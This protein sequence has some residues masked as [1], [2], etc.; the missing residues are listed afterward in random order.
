MRHHQALESDPGS[1]ILF[2]GP[3]LDSNSSPSVISELGLSSS[4]NEQNWLNGVISDLST[5][6]AGASER[7]P[8]SELVPVERHLANLRR[9]L[10][11]LPSSEVPEVLPNAVLAPLTVLAQSRK[12]QIYLQDHT[13]HG[14]DAHLA[15]KYT[16]PLGFC[17]GLLTR[18]A[19][20]S[21]KSLEDL[22]H[23]I[24]VAIRLA[25]LIGA[26]V[27]AEEQHNQHGPA[28][29]F[30]AKWRH[31]EGELDL[32]RVTGRYSDYAYVSVR[33]DKCQ[34]TVTASEHVTS[35]LTQEL[36][37]VG[38]ITAPI[39]LRGRFH[40]SKHQEAFKALISL[41][42]D[43]PGLRFRAVPPADL[44]RHHFDEAVDLHEYALRSILLDECNWYGTLSS[45]L[46]EQAGSL[47][48][49]T[50]TTLDSS[51]CVP[52]SLATRLKSRPIQKSM[53][54]LGSSDV[55]QHDRDSSSTQRDT[56]NGHGAIANNSHTPP[57]PNLCDIAIVGM[58]IK[59]A[60]A[61]DLGEFA[62]LIRTGQSQHREVSADR[63]PLD[64]S[65]WRKKNQDNK[66]WYGNFM[67]DVDSFDHKFF[68]KTPREC[69]AMDPQQRLTLQAAYQAVEQSGYFNNQMPTTHNN[70]IGVYIGACA[71]DYAD[72]A[73]CHE[74]R[75]FTVMGLLRAPIAG[76]VSH[77]F[78]WTGPSMTLDTACSGAAVSIHLAV[79]AL[80]S[81]ECSAALCGGVNVI[82]NEVWFQNLAGASF[83]SPTGQCKPFDEA[84]DGYC[85]GEGVG[86]V[87]LK[88][89]AAA[90]ADGNQIFGRI[91]GT[92]VYQNHNATPLFVP[93][94]PSLSQLFRDVLQQADL[95][96]ADVSVVE[97]HG[98]GTPVGDPA[99]YEAVLQSLGGSN[100]PAKLALGSVK[101]L[102]GHT[103]SASGVVSLVKVLMMMHGSFIPPQASHYKISHRIRTSATDMIDI[104]TTIQ[105]WP[106]HQKAA[107]V[108]NYG[109]SGSNA[110]LIVT[111]AGFSTRSS[112]QLPLGTALPF[113]ISG[114]DG[115]AIV[116]FCAKL[117]AFINKAKGSISLEDI[118]FSLNRQSN[119]TLP[120]GL[121]FTC[122]SVP[123]LMEQLS[124]SSA[125]TTVAVKPP[126][127]V[128]LCFGGQ[129]SRALSLDRAVFDSTPLMRHHLN[130][131][132]EI[133]QT[134]GVESIFPDIFNG[135]LIDDPVH[136]QTMLFSLQ[137][138][139][140]QCWIDSGVQ[141]EAVVGHSFGEIS[142]LCI[143][144]AL[145]LRDALRMVTQ[146]ATIIRNVWS[147]DS[148]AMMMADG[149]EDL[150]RDLVAEVNR[151]VSISRQQCC[152]ACY[153]GPRNFTLAG[154]TEAITHVA[155]VLSTNPTY[156][157]IRSKRL[158][159]TNAFHS[160][161]VQPLLPSLR[162][163]GQEFEFRTPK[164]RLERATETSSN[165]LPISPNFP[166]DHM[167]EPVFFHHAVRR[168]VKDYPSAIWL[169]AGSGS[170][171]T[172]VVRRTAETD[173]GAYF[174]PVNVNRN[175]GLDS[176]ADITLSLWKQGL[177]AIFW[178]HH[179]PYAAS[180]RKTL[181]LP[182]YQ[183]EKTQH[184][185]E[186]VPPVPIKAEDQDSKR[187]NDLSGGLWTFTGFQDRE[188]R[189]ALFKV[190]TKSNTFVEFVK[191]HSLVQTAPICPATLQYS[192]VIEA[193][194]S[195]ME[196]FP[197]L[198]GQDLYPSINDM[199]NRVPLCLNDQS[200]WLD[201][202]VAE[203]VTDYRSWTWKII[204][205]DEG[206]QP[207]PG[208]L[209]HS[210][211][212]VEG[213]L[214]LQTTDGI[215]DFA[216]YE[217]LVTHEQ[218]LS[219]LKDESEAQDILQ[220]HSVYRS[221][222]PAVDYGEIYR[223][224]VR[225]V[226]R[227]SEC[228]G[229]VRYPSITHTNA[230]VVGWIDDIG[231]LDAFCQVAGVYVNCMQ[232]AS[233]DDVFLATGVEAIIRSPHLPARGKR[234][235]PGS[236][237]HI[238]ARHHAVSDKSF[239]TDLFVF[240]AKSGQLSEIFLG[241]NYSRAPRASLSRL[242]ARLSKA[243]NRASSNEN[244]RAPGTKPGCYGESPGLA[245]QIWDR[246]QDET[247]NE[248]T[249]DQPPH[250][251]EQRVST[252][253]QNT[254]IAQ[255]T[256]AVVANML[257]IQPDE[258]SDDSALADMGIDSLV[259]MELTQEIE[260]AFNC[261]LPTTE[262]LLE[263]H[264]LRELIVL[265]G[266]LVHGSSDKNPSDVF[267][268]SDMLSDSSSIARDTPLYSG[269]QVTSEFTP[270]ENT[271]VSSV[272]HQEDDLKNSFSVGDE[273]LPFQVPQSE[274]IR[275]FDNVKKSTDERLR[276]FG[277]DQTDQITVAR[278][279]RLCVALVVEAFELL[280]CSLRSAKAGQPLMRI[281]H[282]PQHQRL[283]D[284]LYRF[285]E[286]DARL[287]DTSEGQLI[288]TR[289]TIGAQT[290]EFILQNLIDAQD[291]WAH[292]HR[293]VYH[294]GKS[295]AD[296]LMGKTDGIAVIFGSVRGR[297]LV[298]ALYCDLPFNRLFYEQMRDTIGSLARS[299]PLNSVE[300]LRILEMGAGTCS[301]TIV[302]APYLASL[303][304][305]VVYTVTDLSPS[306]VAQAR[307]NF[308]SQYPFMKFATHDIEQEP[309]ENLRNQHIVV[310]SNA[311]HATHDLPNSLSK[312]RSA[313][314]SNG[315]LLL[316]EMTEG[317][318][319]VDLVFGLLEGW[320]R[321][322]DGRTNAIVS[323]THWD[324][325]LRNA[326]FQYVDWTDGRLPENHIQK[327]IMAI[328]SNPNVEVSQV[329]R[330]EYQAE[331]VVRLEPPRRA[332]DCHNYV[333]KYV[334]GFMASSDKQRGP[335]EKT[336]QGADGIG[337]VITGATGS[338]GSHLVAC[339]AE[340]PQISQVVI[341]DRSPQ[342]SVSASQRMRD[343]FESRK[344]PVKSEI[345]A[346]LRFVAVD[347]TKPELGLSQKD[348]QSLVVSCTHIIHNGWPMSA[349]RVLASFEP[350]FKSIRHLIDLAAD[351]STYQKG[352]AVPERVV[353]QF[354][355]SI[356]TVGLHSSPQHPR[357]PE[358]TVSIQYALTVGYCEAKW[359]C[360]RLVEET[361]QQHPD[362]FRAMILRPGQIAGST[363]N[364]AWNSHE[365]FAFMLKSAQSLR[366]FPSLEG[367]LQWIPVDT[368]AG[369]MSDLAL[370]AQANC[371]VYH[372][373]N[374][375]GQPWKEMV[376]VLAES[377]NIPSSNIIPFTDWV[378]RVRRSP[379][380]EMD[381]P[382]LR[383]VDFLDNFFLHMSCGG[384]ILD[385]TK[386]QEHSPTLA[387]RGPI[388]A[389]LANKYVRWWKCEGILNNV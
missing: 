329:P 228:A 246:R 220:G 276:A 339:L 269:S 277:V 62:D 2:F 250:D 258:I 205:L 162:E 150:I 28:S 291:P 290:S 376:P 217:R 29:A 17:I 46:H 358:E 86:F 323:A 248:I 170:S 383:V 144:G 325:C 364:G 227:P 241:I 268:S 352:S 232:S 69:A 9:V 73:A 129:A 75:A 243:D 189:H 387:A 126:R 266:K 370:N 213:R 145:E 121:F 331:E 96:P 52:P 114:L 207:F 368:V 117:T 134:L 286:H 312:I 136:L 348:Y 51:R 212:C 19:V 48:S 265:I 171:I 64:T 388:P 26:V 361:L 45:V 306:M 106:E 320:W 317:F 57:C 84:A 178:P 179:G 142:A 204:A 298:K 77:F 267:V 14:S 234:F 65:Q 260:R 94:A 261:K 21:A 259:S 80:L 24:T 147:A 292:A 71:V 11:Q 119:R 229:T 138:T 7:I 133:L 357:I 166:A 146:R 223:G 237:W 196:E 209:K 3:Q 175:G 34:A 128:I 116:E 76:R 185:L 200:V 47:G 198:K 152:I 163:M 89:M 95:K 173:Q 50:H 164:I 199:S 230:G 22:S 254:N 284:W 193:L 35:R 342:S 273:A 38:I 233:A 130:M 321:F 282:E 25:L 216:R 305:P 366:L 338:L 177:R 226:G 313:L 20:L 151:K 278:S 111:N 341:L 154:S 271:H 203:N 356:G 279:T 112:S 61:D 345:F 340:N 108:N 309:S 5:L 337:V 102:V 299:L 381:N 27:D 242:V 160:N 63:I 127:P 143:S 174:Q 211:V 13:G 336:C 249:R 155:F 374:P 333:T 90:I 42:A 93:N 346:K 157:T 12:Y 41:C 257:G 70:H 362:L 354:V 158:D 316:T 304:I 326:G 247:R 365:H 156:N 91:A 311:V 172:S 79:R 252:D 202:Q 1:D 15:A 16:I 385:T 191:D 183:F 307:R 169:E 194:F 314:T 82:A 372:M 344:M 87:F 301:T 360:E 118:E 382:A 206:Q 222:A 92:A 295:L 54:S 236:M 210:S 270:S 165:G 6:W 263:A 334:A 389:E 201:L 182:P 109:A 72:N 310:A 218:C 125:L 88:P 58:S 83:L 264:D 280:G 8:N 188:K 293:L 32:N 318:P 23:Q 347:L 332:E 272:D 60:G 378:R 335:Y 85:R 351:M 281:H 40:T 44:K 251:N 367:T 238:W 297:E 296:V 113:W 153:N 33:F 140:A 350:Q 99:E 97:A 283:I 115:R 110:A 184:W 324:K 355:S 302:L 384:I 244:A 224:V 103:E 68:R 56:T 159:V 308:G 343:A 49:L 322:N 373:D 186:Y 369:A 319:F 255:E 303:N 192:M 135:N 104:P 30:A 141:V 208:Q 100:R 300:P 231:V 81:G 148:G 180:S 215:R 214:E 235:E 98:T 359:V 287:L 18:C 105:S 275:A 379:L 55:F 36:H 219:M 53:G 124:S 221:L 176:L 363:V 66:A 139:C 262:L 187:A 149:D 375:S 137:Y 225:V 131:C 289:I 4:S 349:N 386:A 101:G 67:R 123:D 37:E 239:L 132:D 274:I 315:V 327:V 78:G 328:A 197:S 253:T 120:R 59:V 167:I 380:R 285:L 245:T 122:K 181:L 161:L 256:R 10:L 240:D 330:L 294:A 43:E 31:P 377:L 195:L 353:F 107:L 371:P 39:R 190:N 168:L 74:A 288:R